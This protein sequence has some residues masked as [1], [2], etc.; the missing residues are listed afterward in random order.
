[1]LN[2]LLLTYFLRWRM[3]VVSEK[4]GNF[5]VIITIIEMQMKC[6]K[7]CRKLLFF[8]YVQLFPNLLTLLA[9]GKK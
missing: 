4:E 8:V 9:S 3:L 6:I 7:V 1:M 2:A 5:D